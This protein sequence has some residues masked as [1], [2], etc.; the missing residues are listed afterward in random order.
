MHAHSCKINTLPISLINN[1]SAKKCFEYPYSRAS[2]FE[3]VHYSNNDNNSNNKTTFPSLALN[4]YT[5]TK[6][7]YR[8]MHT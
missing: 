4:V 2:Q 5:F 8:K 7:P 3:V 1:E 6:I